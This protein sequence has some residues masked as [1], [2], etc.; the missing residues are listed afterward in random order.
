MTNMNDPLQTILERH[1]RRKDSLIPILQ[2][3]QKEYRYL[4]RA[5]LRKIV[6]ETEISAADVMRV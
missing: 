1:G 6:D 2:A 3:V 4:P 5:V